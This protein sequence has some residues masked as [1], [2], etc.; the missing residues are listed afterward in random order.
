MEWFFKE[1]ERLDNDPSN[2]WR[3]TCMDQITSEMISSLEFRT[4]KALEISG[5]KW[6]HFGFASYRSAFYPEFDICNDVLT[7]KYDIIIAEQV[8]EH[9]SYPYGAAT[10]VFKILNA[11]GYFLITTPFLIKYHPAPGDCSRWS[12]SGLKFFLSECSFPVQNIE[13]GSLGNKQCLIENL[14]T[15]VVYKKDKHSLENETEYPLCVWA[16]ARK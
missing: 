13:R 14:E 8:F 4:F 1:R 15:W 10:N 7:D 2:Q 9:V 5:D 12:E 3:R 11:N 16:L 6:E